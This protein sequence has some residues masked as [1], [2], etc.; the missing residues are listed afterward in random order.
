M[1][2]ALLATHHAEYAANLAMALARRH[3]VLLVL[4]ARNAGRQLLRT[5]WSVLRDAVKLKVVPHH[6]APLQPW[7]GWRCA[8]IV[9]DFAP[10]VVHVQEHPSR[11]PAIAVR[12]MAGGYP[13]VVTIHDPRP[14]S[15]AD[16]AAA[17]VFARQYESLRGAADAMVVHGA[18]LVRELAG[19]LPD[20][21]ARVH[22]VPHGVL[23]FGS[24]RADDFPPAPGG[25]LIF[26]GRM[27]RYKGLDLLLDANDIWRADG[28]APPLIVAGAGPE[29]ARLSGRLAAAPNIELHGRHL[30]QPELA[31]L[32]SRASAA[33]LPYR[34]ATQSGAAASCFG[35]G[36]PVIATAVGGLPEVIR[37]GENGLL[38]APDDAA[39]LA[40][41]GLRLM[42]DAGLHAR[43]TQGA[44]ATAA[45]TLAWT[46]IADTTI[47]VYSAAITS[48]RSGS[49][50][51]QTLSG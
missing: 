10:D 4:S 16:A 20:G 14:H 15:G 13:V 50:R 41:A 35:A 6:Y 8:A 49:A 5:S 27:N 45:R 46:D 11:A 40:A 17:R 28:E 7:I 21:A 25:P 36:R 23:R 12:R 48:H 33:I 19:L 18:A 37:D 38:V 30:S 2:I 51:R 9:R 31:K 47:G 44:H 42:R 24:L 32:V 1:K 22:A 26:F 3:E 43:L 34:D 39:A 29:I